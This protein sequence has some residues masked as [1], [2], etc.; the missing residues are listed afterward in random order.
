MRLLAGA[1]EVVR[2]ENRGW[3][4]GLSHFAELSAEFFFSFWVGGCWGIWE[5]RILFVLRLK[6]SLQV[7]NCM[8]V[9]TGCLEECRFR[10]FDNHVLTPFILRRG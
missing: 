5:E 8:R 3:Q 2:R 9:S 4:S 7:M 1:V 10:M 6:H